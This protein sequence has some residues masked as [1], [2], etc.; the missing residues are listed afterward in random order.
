MAV[1]TA[2]APKNFHNLTDAE[3]DRLNLPPAGFQG[4]EFT[5]II[6]A[7]TKNALQAKISQFRAFAK[8]NKYDL[9]E[10]LQQGPDPDGGF[11]AVITAHN[12]NPLT[13]AAEKAHRTYLG[14]KHGVAI[15]TQ[16]AII[17]HKVGTEA[18]IARAG[19]EEK[20]LAERRLARLRAVEAERLR[21]ETVYAAAIA[22]SRYQG[23]TSTSLTTV[24]TGPPVPPTKEVFESL[25]EAIFG[26]GVL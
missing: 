6:Q 13:W 25:N 1:K 9:F 18:A 15:G 20:A 16:K 24:P 11:K 12:W 17:K 26:K 21:G 14:A 5:T 7:P 22:R 10:I 2:N 19:E 3:R 8:V 23:L 4:N